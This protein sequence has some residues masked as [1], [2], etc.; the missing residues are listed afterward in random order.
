MTQIK[1]Y[2]FSYSLNEGYHL[3]LLCIINWLM[4][5]IGQLFFVFFCSSD[6][7]FRIY[8]IKFHEKINKLSRLICISICCLKIEFEHWTFKNGQKM[9]YGDITRYFNINLPQYCTYYKIY[10]HKRLPRVTGIYLYVYDINCARFN[11]IM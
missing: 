6:I 1:L 4:P 9:S 11:A 3:I 8:P 10:Y 7:I 5:T 2:I